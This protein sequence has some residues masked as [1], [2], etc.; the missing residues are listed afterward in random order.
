MCYQPSEESDPVLAKYCEHH[1]GNGES[2]A[3][4][5]SWFPGNPDV[6]GWFYKLFKAVWTDAAFMRDPPACLENVPGAVRSF[7]LTP[8][9]NWIHMLL[10]FSL[11][12]W[13]WILCMKIALWETRAAL[14]LRWHWRGHSLCS[15]TSTH[16]SHPVSD[17]D[18]YQCNVLDRIATST[19]GQ[20]SHLSAFC[21]SKHKKAPKE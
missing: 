8:P 1:R 17:G 11:I 6:T 12:V 10:L 14:M 19:G 4:G 2:G 3:G 9:Q 21:Q 15:Q 18:F 13:R 7:S 20:G 5:D 16:R